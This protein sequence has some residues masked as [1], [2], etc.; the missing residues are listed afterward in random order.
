MELVKHF[1]DSNIGGVAGEKRV[2]TN[3]NQGSVVV[4]G[5]YWQYESKLR[6][7]DSKVC[8]VTG[9]VG[10]LY[11]VRSELLLPVPDD[12]ICEDMLI[13]MRIIDRGKKVIYEPLA[14]GV[15]YVSET[16]ADEWK[17]KKRIGAGSIQFYQRM[18][19][20]PFITRQPLAAFQF[21]SRKFFRWLLVPYALI[22]LPFLSLFIIYQ[23]PGDWL[24]VACVF[25]LTF[26]GWAV[27]GWMSINFRKLPA[28]F[29][30]PFYF[31]MANMAIIVGTFQYLVG[32]S[33]VV[34]ERVKR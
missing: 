24:F 15:E 11:A 29:F 18:K 10:E 12:T 6:Q 31:M 20:L 7:W 3:N 32:K 34:W 14:Y 19:L 16:I 23:K 9:A 17:R 4:E 33:F 5:F 27:I 28:V 1:Q 8:S 25:Q 30:F 21:I 26:F 2:I 22:V 13:T